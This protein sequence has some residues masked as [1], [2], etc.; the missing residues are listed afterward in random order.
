MVGTAAN[1]SAASGNPVYTAGEGFNGIAFAPRYCDKTAQITT[2]GTTV[3]VQQI[4]AV[5]SQKIYI[6]GYFVL[7]STATTAVTLKWTE[8]TGSNCVTGQTNVTPAI[9]TT[10]ISAPTTANF[11]LGPWGGGALAWTTTAAD[12]LCITQ[13][14]GTNSTTLSGVIFYTQN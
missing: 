11:T 4:A 1:G 6:C 10:P 8:G 12:A 3:T 13:S 5:A 14:S 7:A 9:F 2:L